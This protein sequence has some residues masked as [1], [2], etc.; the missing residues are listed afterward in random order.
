MKPSNIELIR[1]KPDII[2][3]LRSVMTAGLIISNAFY[4]RSCYSERHLVAGKNSRKNRKQCNRDFVVAG[5]QVFLKARR[6]ISNG[7]KPLRFLQVQ[8]VAQCTSGRAE[9]L[10]C[11]FAFVRGE[12][13]GQE[14]TFCC[15]AWWWQCVSTATGRLFLDWVGMMKGM[16]GI[17]CSQL[18]VSQCD[19][20]T[21]RAESSNHLW[22]L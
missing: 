12:G 13:S 15:L 21:A 1:C 5:N 2:R 6:F 4:Q 11:G 9:R 3:V 22:K 7:G 16:W 17:I 19:T 10:Y 18:T 14:H 8:V 20:L